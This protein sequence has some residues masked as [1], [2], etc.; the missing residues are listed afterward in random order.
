MA[1]RLP[2]SKLHLIRD[3]IE[4][5][6]LS[7]SQMAEEAECSKVTIINIR[8]NLRQFGNV[9]APPNRIGRRRTVTPPMIEA[10]CDHLSEKPGLYLDEMAVFLWDEFHTLATTS[11]I[12]RALVARGWSKKTARQQARERNGDL[13]E[14][15]LHNLSDFQSY[16]L[17]YV[18]ESGCD[19]R[20]G[21][22]RTGWSPLGVAPI[23]VSQFHRD[24]RYQI[25]PA[26]AQDGI[27]LSRVFRGSTDATMFE[28]FIAQLLQHCGK[29]P[30]PKSV[31]I[32]DNAS[33]HHS[34][35][36]AQMCADAGVILIYL[37]PYSPDLNPIEEFFAELKAFIK[38]NWGYYEAD[39]DQGFDAFLTWCI[40]IVG[41]KEESAKG[42]FRHA[43]LKIEEILERS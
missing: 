37:P 8:R 42:H 38:R 33:F 31:V 16:H 29:W 23:Q 24:Q 43:G 3:M 34:E 13:R 11:S 14:Y 41:A 40:D 30:E 19:K 39:P 9:H 22:R 2:L 4:S 7:T 6:S 12:R 26:Y 28:D 35:R 5:Q 17:V 27:V 25:L 32:M 10:L 36:I 18:D 15:Y 21:F 20:V 1:P